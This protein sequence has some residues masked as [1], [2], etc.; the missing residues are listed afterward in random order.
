MIYLI[1]R[2]Y[3]INKYAYFLRDNT[4]SSNDSFWTTLVDRNTEETKPKLS[5][6]LISNIHYTTSFNYSVFFICH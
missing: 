2:L 5:N 3:K 6:N 4:Q 1:D